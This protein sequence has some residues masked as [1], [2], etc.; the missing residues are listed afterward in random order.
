[1]STG[2]E[3][4]P[5][6]IAAGVGVVGRYRARRAENQASGPAPYAFQTR[7]QDEELFAAA[8]TAVGVTNPSGQGATG[9][10][11]VAGVPMSMARTDSGAFEAVF[12]GHIGQDQAKAALEQVDGEY[13]RL[14]QERVY[15]Q[16]IEQ[17]Q[18]QGLAVESEQV[19][20]DNSIILTLR[21][22]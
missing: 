6:A 14:V 15:H 17:A 1:M 3:L 18:S 22:D 2:L 9:V 16:V 20:G 13:A 12:P 10:T 21:V 11:S 8:V 7:M 4:I 19:E 5:F